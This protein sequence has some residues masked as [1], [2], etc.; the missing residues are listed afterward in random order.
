MSALSCKMSASTVLISSSFSAVTLASVSALNNNQAPKSTTAAWTV[1]KSGLC[2]FSI[3]YKRF[4][5]FQTIVPLYI[6]LAPKKSKKTSYVFV[7]W[8]R[9]CIELG[10]EGY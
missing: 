8:K 5:Y 1:E 2:C 10:L 3:F 6:L 9:F 4:S 7:K